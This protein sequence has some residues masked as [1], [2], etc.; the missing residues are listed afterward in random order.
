V[1]ARKISYHV[2]L[3]ET[4]RQ[5]KEAAHFPVLRFLF[6]SSCSIIFL[7]SAFFQTSR[8]KQWRCVRFIISIVNLGGLFVSKGHNFDHAW[9]FKS[10]WELV[11][12]PLTFPE[13]LIKQHVI[14]VLHR[15]AR[16]MV[17]SGS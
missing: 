8:G 16:W 5:T 15:F 13:M 9:P 1:N 3:E 7:C 14:G 2:S 4:Q 11:R 12:A 6:A 10:K 17:G